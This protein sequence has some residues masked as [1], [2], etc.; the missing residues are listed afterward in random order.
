MADVPW[1]VLV[2]EDFERWWRALPDEHQDALTARIAMLRDHG[3]ALGRPTVDTIQAS[4]LANL[5]EIR[6][7]VGRAHLRVLFVF[8]PAR[9]AVLL[10]AGNKTGQWQS[11]YR[12]SIPEAERLYA[13]HVETMKKRSKP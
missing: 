7:S 9:R 13:E 3:P 10:V 1:E 2:T 8:D 6:A 12:R 5:K 4:R 11:W